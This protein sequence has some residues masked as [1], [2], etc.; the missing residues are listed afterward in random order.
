MTDKDVKMMPFYNLSD[1]DK[2]LILDWRNHKNVSK[3]MHN[4]KKVSI[5]EHY[6][7]IKGLRNNEDKKYF[8]IKDNEQKIGVVSFTKIEKKSCEFGI[9]SNPKCKGVGKFLMR[10]IISY[11]F[12][13]LLVDKIYAEVYADNIKAINLYKAFGCFENS[14]K[15][16]NGKE[17]I[18]MEL[19]NEV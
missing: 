6:L 1:E 8:L 4:S 5:Q 12:N 14:R 18:C 2:L 3:W 16:S 13:I 17:V 11:A 7:F 10:K 19:L 9:Y 15:I